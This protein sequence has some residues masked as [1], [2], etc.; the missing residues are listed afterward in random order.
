VPGIYT[1]SMSVKNSTVS[2]AVV[3][4][5]EVRVQNRVSEEIRGLDPDMDAYPLSVGVVLDPSLIT[6][7]V[8]EGWKLSA[9]G[10]PSGLSFKN[11]IVSG[12]PSKAGNYTVTFTAT[13]GSGKSKRTEQA[14]ITLK[15][16]SL[17]VTAT[18]T[19]T[20]IVTDNE[21][22]SVAGTFTATVTAAGKI[23]ATVNT[24]AKKYSFSAKAWD[25]FAEGKASVGIAAKDSCLTMELDSEETWR[26]W[27]ASGDV[28]IG[29]KT[30]SLSAQRNPYDAKTGDPDAIAAISAMA[31]KSTIDGWTIKIDK[32]GAVAISGKY[33][34]KSLSG[35]STLQY[36]ENICE[37]NS[38]FF[39]RYVKFPD[40]KTVLS[41]LF[42][43][44]EQGKAISWK[45]E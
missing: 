37:D 18:G 31:G 12:T 21:D 45:V 15:V 5:F 16:A 17:P 19:F 26:S 36:D 6:P 34:G 4:N 44:D 2:A 43:F 39:A 7:E 24:P 13:M 10:L 42:F 3:T 1:V 35:S 25:A 28:I 11:G 22:K 33:D 23:S 29:E 38:G 27:Q 20:G 41:L 8:D 14:T 40:K 32:K 9:S 30:Y